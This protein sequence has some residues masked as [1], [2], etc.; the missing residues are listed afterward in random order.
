[1]RQMQIYYLQSPTV[2]PFPLQDNADW[3]TLDV[4]E[5]NL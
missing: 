2:L 3:D 5:A 1:M 4:D